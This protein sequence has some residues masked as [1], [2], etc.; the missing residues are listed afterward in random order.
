MESSTKE[1]LIG[2]RN[3]LIFE[4]ELE[5]TAEL[6]KKEERYFKQVYSIQTNMPI[7][8]IRM[9]QFPVTRRKYYVIAVTPTR[10]YQFIGTVSPNSSNGVIGGSEDK[11]MFESL[12]SKYEVNPGKCDILDW[13]NG[14]KE[15]DGSNYLRFRSFLSQDSLSFLETFHTA[16]FTFSARFRI[17]STKE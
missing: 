5:P 17:C 2:T 16:N 3:G 11:A 8:G 7:T 10:I 9:E 4:A 13:S 14:E 15:K 1:F 6:F 12:F